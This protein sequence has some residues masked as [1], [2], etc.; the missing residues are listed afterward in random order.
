[1]N[2]AIALG[3]NLGDRRAHLEWAI[4]RLAEVLANLRVSTLIET[5]PV[6]VPD[7]QPAYL[8]GVVVGET[9]LG[10][11]ALLEYLMALESER[12]RER[13]SFRAART[14]DLDVILYGDRII[15]TSTIE[16]PHPRFRDREFVLQPLAELAPDWI[17][18]VSRK[19]VK[20]L[21]QGTGRP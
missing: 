9:D 13:R 8:N 15:K 17:D 1:M 12:G 21:L 14:L 4:Q 7:E 16:I 20:E 6:G 10:P 5:D 3:S 11:E 18:P 2:V 19:T